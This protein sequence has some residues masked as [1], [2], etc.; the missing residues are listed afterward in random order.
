MANITD[1][2]LLGVLFS[3]FSVTSSLLGPQL[4]SWHF[5]ATSSAYQPMLPTYKNHQ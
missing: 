4:S 1:I 3:F 5:S 2:K